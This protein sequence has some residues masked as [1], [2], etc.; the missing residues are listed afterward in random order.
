MSVRAIGRR[1]VREELARIAFNQFCLSNFEDV[2]FADLAGAAGVSRSTFLRYFLN[3]E[4][5]VLFAFDPIGD[6]VVDALDSRP[7]QGDDWLKLRRALDPV[8]D[9]LK[10]DVGEVIRFLQLIDRTPTLSARF[11]QKQFDW[12]QGVVDKLRQGEAAPGGPSIV[13][14]VRVAAALECLSM[15]LAN[16]RDSEGQENLSSLLDTAFGALAIPATS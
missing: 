5:V 4:D 12:R 9:F 7:A 3:K 2:T 14:N 16:W 1:A 6:I 15:A 11:R 10:R 13:L 8:V